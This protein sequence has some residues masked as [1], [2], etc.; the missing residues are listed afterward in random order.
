MSKTENLTPSGNR[1]I[2]AYNASLIESP[3]D[4]AAAWN[5]VGA[6]LDTYVEE[7][8]REERER[9]LRAAEIYRDDMAEAS[10]KASA[11][12]AILTYT[13]AAMAGAAIADRI[14]ALSP[15]TQGDD[16]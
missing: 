15:S 6:L 4:A 9:C 10:E 13:G 5:A 11:E 7:K 3:G 2:D 8:V 12:G 1:A 14:R 16:D